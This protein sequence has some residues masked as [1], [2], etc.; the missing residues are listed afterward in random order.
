M[1]WEAGKP[2]GKG[3]QAR[4]LKVCLEACL[5]DVGVCIPPNRRV[6]DIGFDVI[7][8]DARVGI[9]VPI[10]SN[11]IVFEGTATPVRRKGFIVIARE[12]ELVEVE[13]VCIPG[14]GAEDWF[15][16]EVGKRFWET[17]VKPLTNEWIVVA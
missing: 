13:V 5:E 16:H 9:E 11:R 3:S 1:P 10:E 2:G 17:R 8:H 4:G 6:V 14:S 12:E 15:G 7:H